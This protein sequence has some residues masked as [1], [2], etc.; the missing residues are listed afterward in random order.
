MKKILL[1]LFLALAMSSAHA[2]FMGYLQWPTQA[3]AQTFADDVHAWMYANDAAYKISVDLGQ[4]TRWDVPHINLI[5]QA[6]PL[7]SIPDPTDKRW[8]IIT[9][10]RCWGA[11]TGAQQ[12]MVTVGPQTYM[13]ADDYTIVMSDSTTGVRDF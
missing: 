3:S 12:S 5:E 9:T 6:F 7:P 8:Y 13:L 4:T 11:L 1:G 10:M 2:Q